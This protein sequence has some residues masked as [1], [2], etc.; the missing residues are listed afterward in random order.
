MHEALSCAVILTSIHNLH[1]GQALCRGGSGRGL[2]RA[3]LQDVGAVELVPQ[4]DRD[5]CAGQRAHHLFQ[6]AITCEPQLDH[7]FAVLDA[8]LL[9]SAHL[10]AGVTVSGAER[11]KV[12]SS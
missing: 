11:S 1:Q 8:Q 3:A 4:T 2:A 7:F 12:M 9:Q 10:V 5:E 6:K